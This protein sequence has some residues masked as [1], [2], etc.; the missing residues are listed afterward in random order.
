MPR[1]VGAQ[2]VA[3]ND[4]ALRVPHVP[5]LAPLLRCMGRFPII[6]PSQRGLAVGSNGPTVGG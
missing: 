2:D 3:V 6:R 5:G 4:A 1:I